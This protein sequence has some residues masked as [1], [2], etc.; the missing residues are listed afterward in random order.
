MAPHRSQSVLS[1]TVYIYYNYHTL[2][3]YCTNNAKV[4]TLFSCNDSNNVHHVF[5]FR[6]PTQTW[7]AWDCCWILKT[8]IV[9]SQNVVHACFRT[10]YIP[11]IYM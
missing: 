4:K 5:I 2:Q 9:P 1:H 3:L 10:Q 7:H 6:I 8:N 11:Y